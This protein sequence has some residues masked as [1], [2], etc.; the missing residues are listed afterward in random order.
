M[1]LCLDQKFAC[2][3]I[4]ISNLSYTEVI[5]PAS[6]ASQGVHYKDPTVWLDGARPPPKVC[7]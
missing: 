5:F 4:K 3:Y 1:V 6:F 2:K 7:L